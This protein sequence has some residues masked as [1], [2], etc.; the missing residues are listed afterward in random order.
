MLSL[1]SNSEVNVTLS[2]FDYYPL[3][4][5]HEPIPIDE[6]TVKRDFEIICAA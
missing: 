2:Y 4:E 5:F 3:R 1:R 6:R